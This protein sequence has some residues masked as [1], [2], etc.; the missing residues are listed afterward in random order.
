[1]FLEGRTDEA[2]Q[3]V[4]RALNILR[5]DGGGGSVREAQYLTRLA[6]MN[7]G[8]GEFAAANSALQQVLQFCARNAEKS[9]SESAEAEFQLAELQLRQGKLPDADA[10]YKKALESD[11]AN[12]SSSG[13]AKAA[14]LLGY[15]SFLATHDAR[16]A[17]KMAIEARDIEAKTFGAD[18]WL[19]DLADSVTATVYAGEGR[20]AEA[21]ALGGKSYSN[22]RGKLGADARAP[23]AAAAR[24]A[25]VYRAM[26]KPVPGDLADTGAK[27]RSALCCF[28]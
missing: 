19:L 21:R 10:N 11:R 23:L 24:L 6:M 2:A 25:A 27:G 20:Y 4:Q 13:F 18:A 14:H 9:Q 5:V 16:Q 17:E 26:G 8:R 15:A 7:T 12:R 28:Y 3:L 22:L 1:L